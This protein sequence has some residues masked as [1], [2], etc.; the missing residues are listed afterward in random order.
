MYRFLLTPRWWAINVFV[1]LAVPICLA[2]GTWQLSRF[3]A[4]VDS[5]REQE[6]LAEGEGEVRPLAELLPLTTETVGHQ[7]EI[8]GSFDAEH[9]LLVPERMVDGRRGFYVLTP[10]RPTDGSPAVPVVRG[11][12][13]GRADPAAAPEP[14]AGEVTVV[15][16]L[17]AAESPSKVS[18]RTEGLAPG[19]LG[20]IG[21]ASLI[22]VLPYEV[23]DSW[24]TVREPEPPLV[25]VPA[26]APTGTGLDLDAFQNLGYTAEWF[27]FAGFAVFMWFRLFRREVEQ[28][29]DRELG[30]TDEG[31]AP[32]GGTA[33]PG[34]PNGPDRP[35]R[36]TGPGGPK[37]RDEPDERA[38]ATRP[39]R[40]PE[41]PADDLART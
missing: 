36:P 26:T 2:A 22:N 10:L 24:I 30:L 17:Q 15:G 39:N 27:V 32:G 29:R 41:R 40:P 19:E 3:E 23:T 28:Q 13:P 4:Q 6:R 35:D 12:L 1:V 5:H 33:A 31:P 21:A 34:R 8:T 7:A 20:V 9:Q 25:A 18:G 16:A 38:G 14:P 37:T 11:W